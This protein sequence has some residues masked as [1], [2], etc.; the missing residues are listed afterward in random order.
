MFICFFAT[1]FGGRG[2]G[3]RLGFEGWGGG[4]GGG[5][6]KIPGLPLSSVSIPANYF[7]FLLLADFK[8]PNQQ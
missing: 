6:V 4:G 8:M 5:E 2:R 1:L 3:E 7:T